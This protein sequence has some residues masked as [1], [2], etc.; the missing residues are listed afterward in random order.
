MFQKLNLLVFF[1]F[2][3]RHHSVLS[4][5][6]PS[7]HVKKAAQ[8]KCKILQL[9]TQQKKKKIASPEPLSQIYLKKRSPEPQSPFMQLFLKAANDESM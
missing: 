1:L 7:L 5:V 3:M 9:Q 8:L 2:F 6:K 4:I